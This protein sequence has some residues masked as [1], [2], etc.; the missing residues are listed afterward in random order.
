MDGGTFIKMTI[1]G[2]L[3]G[4]LEDLRKK[5][6]VEKLGKGEHVYAVGY[7]WKDQKRPQWY[8]NV[9]IAKTKEELI[10]RLTV[11]G[12]FYNLPRDMVVVRKLR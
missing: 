11:G 4:T 7:K 5:A 8:R 1:G 3:G 2:G 9:A 6:R 10:K 12:Q